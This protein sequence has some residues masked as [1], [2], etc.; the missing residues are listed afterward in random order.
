MA[1][2]SFSNFWVIFGVNHPVWIFVI[3]YTTKGSQEVS[4][5]LHLPKSSF[6]S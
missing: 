1:T 5:F 2:K 6:Y 3:F 4:F